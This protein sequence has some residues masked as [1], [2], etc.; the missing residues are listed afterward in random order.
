MALLK[1]LNEQPDRIVLG[2]GGGS[3]IGTLI[4]IGVF[5][6]VTCVA[7]G[8][9][10]DEGGALDPVMIVIFIV[11]GLAVLASLV[12][13]LASTRVVLDANQ[14][15]ATRTNTLLFVPTQ[16]QEMAFNLIRD[17]QVT[18]LRGSGSF[19][20]DAL[21][22]WQVVLS[23]T[24]GSTLLVNE[25]G[26]RAEMDALAQKVGTLLNRPVRVENETKPTPATNYAPTA[27]MGSLVQNLVAF[28]QS[29]AE[30]SY[31]TT[32]SLFPDDSPRLKQDR[33][34]RER[35]NTP[36]ARATEQLAAE[37]SAANASAFQA[38]ARL[39]AERAAAFATDAQI[40]NQL[41]AEQRAADAPFRAASARLVQAQS[42][43]ETAMDY[44]MPPLLTLPQMPS[45]MSFAP[46]LSLPSL[47]P[48][49]MGFEALAMPLPASVEIKEVEAQVAPTQSE[50]S[51]AR[52]ARSLFQQARQLVSARN[53]RDAEATFL[54][55]L[56][57][58][59]ADAL[60]HN[61]LGVVYFEQN[62]MPDA[63]RAFRRAVAL[64][65]FIIEGRYNLGLV[66]HRLGRRNEAQE[67]FRV[68]VQNVGRGGSKHFQEALRGVLHEP[69]L[70]STR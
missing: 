67:Q 16:R 33:L 68:G 36:Y 47:P 44:S 18:R 38:T 30:S 42:A 3:V 56:S 31:P 1:V 12:N 13:V 8:S 55:V 27:V 39:E 50:T 23:A 6:I 4:G 69:L 62:K 29:A 35:V 37:Q 45:L 28:A 54:R 9:I 22:I 20:L 25:R 49:G 66:L 24:D 64:D 17:V 58:N 60:A 14:R 57:N 52:D 7:L 32:Q 46:A 2:K 26:T 65:P 11:I 43:A 59:P 70:S 10:L 19:T 51:N 61:D 40:Q 48:I 15:L 34:E 53:F 21:P 63:E 5:G 41:G